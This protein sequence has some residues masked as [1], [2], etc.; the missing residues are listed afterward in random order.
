[1]LLSFLIIDLYLLIHVVIT[2]ISNPVAE[3]EIAIGIPT[4]KLK[5]EMEIHQL[6][7]ENYNK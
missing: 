3:L 7:I 5:A 6:I 4:K 2:Q 1:M